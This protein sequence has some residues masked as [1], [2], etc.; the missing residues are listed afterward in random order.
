MNLEQQRDMIEEQIANTDN[1]AQIK[2]LTKELDQIQTEID[3]RKGRNMMQEQRD[4][5]RQ[6]ERTVL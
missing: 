1:V 2:V 3:A 6:F 5:Q 4:K